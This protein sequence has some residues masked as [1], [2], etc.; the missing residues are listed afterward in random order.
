MCQ[1]GW[2]TANNAFGSF[3]LKHNLL[4]IGKKAQ[5]GLLAPW[6]ELRN[7]SSSI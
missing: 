6:I 3:Y 7:Y 4:E 2:F 5:K 1:Y